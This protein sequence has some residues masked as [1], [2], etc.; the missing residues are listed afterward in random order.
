MGYLMMDYNT[1]IK[2]LLTSLLNNRGETFTVIVKGKSRLANSVYII[3]YLL[4]DGSKAEMS[5]YKM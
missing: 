5:D 3:K 1:T 2:V 4:T